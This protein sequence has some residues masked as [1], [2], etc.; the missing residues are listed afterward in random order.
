MCNTRTM[1]WRP[2]FCTSSSNII[3][4]LITHPR[5]PNRASPKQNYFI[6]VGAVI[7]SQT[8]N[9]ING[10]IKGFQNQMDVRLVWSGI[11]MSAQA[12][13]F[14]AYKTAGSATAPTSASSRARQERARNTRARKRKWYT[15]PRLWQWLW[16]LEQWSVAACVIL[17]LFL[18]SG[19]SFSAHLK[20]YRILWWLVLGRVLCVWKLCVSDK[21]K[22]Y[23]M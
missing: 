15:T 9:D 5:R 10:I 13:N 17:K 21:R 19:T 12:R 20:R 16:T 14:H 3:N 23:R 7:I 22:N 6:T 2:S 4:K 8:R 1:S 18:R 11:V